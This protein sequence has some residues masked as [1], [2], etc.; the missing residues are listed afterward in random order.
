MRTDW[1]KLKHIAYLKLT[2]VPVDFILDEF[3]SPYET[4]N[5]ELA[6]PREVTGDRYIGS[7]NIQE[8]VEIIVEICHTEYLNNEEVCEEMEEDIALTIYE[9][10]IDDLMLEGIIRKPPSYNRKQMKVVVNNS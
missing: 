4:E 5:I 2:E 6:I 8:M 1:E 10:L 7:F 3:G 9:R